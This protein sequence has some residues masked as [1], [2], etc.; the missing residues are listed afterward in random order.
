MTQSGMSMTMTDLQD[1]Y[2]EQLRDVYSAETQLVGALPRMA[3]AASN[4]DLKRGFELHLEQ[5]QQQAGRL[6]QIF[7]DL[8]EAPGGHTCKAM[9]GLIAE[10]E[11]M[12]R[13]K[14]VPAVKDAGLIAASQRIEHYE[15]AAYGTV[16]TYAEILG[17]PQDA[18][19][20]RTSEDEEK[21]TDQKL[22]GLARSINMEAMG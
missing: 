18:E 3:Q 13:E 17:R 11:D 7:Q 2:L 22:T 14:A 21:A 15:I 6:E 16:R 9:Q 10:G 12:I 8:G 4:P 5:T 19:L 20:L 1:L